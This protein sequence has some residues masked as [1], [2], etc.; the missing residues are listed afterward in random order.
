MA[1]DDGMYINT[2]ITYSISVL[3]TTWSVVNRVVKNSAEMCIYRRYTKTN[4]RE[5]LLLLDEHVKIETKKK[6]SKQVRNL[7]GKILI[8]KIK[9]V[10]SR[11]AMN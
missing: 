11:T 1:V 9:L 7:L 4:V 6:N 2:A 8:F 10:L 3:K 5:G